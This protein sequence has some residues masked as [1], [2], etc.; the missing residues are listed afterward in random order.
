MKALIRI[1]KKILMALDF[2]N[3]ELYL[4]TL[5]LKNLTWKVL[6]WKTWVALKRILRWVA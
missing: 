4:K 3:E 6:V 5:V 2:G 1:C